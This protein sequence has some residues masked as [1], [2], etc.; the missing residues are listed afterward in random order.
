MHRLQCDVQDPA[1]MAHSKMA[2][3]QRPY[4]VR[5]VSLRAQHNIITNDAAVVRSDSAGD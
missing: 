5:T 4:C 2:L 1:K 3:F